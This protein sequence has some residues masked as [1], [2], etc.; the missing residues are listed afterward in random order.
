MNS[1]RVLCPFCGDDRFE[2]QRVE[3]LYSHAEKYLLVPNMP[4]EACLNCGMI[5]YDAN[6][7]EEVEQHFFAIHQHV[8]KPD[9]YVQVPMMAY[10]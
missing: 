3:Y 7:L 2:E 4:V 10:A 8:E 9:S 6:V 1:R 5:F